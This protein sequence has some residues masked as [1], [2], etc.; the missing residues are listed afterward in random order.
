MHSPF[1][2]CLSST[3][4]PE[5]SR[6]DKVSDF[7]S[8]VGD[9]QTAWWIF[10]VV[11]SIL[12]F[13]SCLFRFRKHINQISLE[14][15]KAFQNTQKYIPEIYTELNQNMEF[16][17]Y[18]VHSKTWKRRVI[19]E[20]NRMF[21][22][23]LGKKIASVLNAPC[24][25]NKLAPWAS[26]GSIIT[27]LQER[28]QFLQKVKND[29][30]SNYREIGEFYFNLR[31]YIYYLPDELHV[32]QERCE[33]MQTQNMIVIGS[34]GNGKTNLLCRLVESI[35]FSKAPC[36]FINARDIH[37]DCISYVYGRILP[38]FSTR[39]A[40]VFLRIVCCALKIQRNYFYIIIDAIN[41]NDSDLFA[42]SIGKLTEELSQFSRIKFLCS[43]RSEY[44]EARYKRFFE[45]SKNQPHIFKLEQVDYTDRAKEKMLLAYRSFFNVAV[46]LSANVVDRLMHS[47]FLMR[48]FFEVNK[49]KSGQNLELRD[50]EIYKAYFDIVT[51]KTAPFDFRNA[52]EKASAIMISSKRF[53]G[54]NITELGLSTADLVQFRNALD[55]NLII[56]RSIHLG[57]GITERNSEYIY[58][59][60][61]ELRDYSLARHLLVS[62]E[63]KGDSQYLHFFEFANDLFSSKLSPLEGILKYAYYHFKHAG[64]YTL[65]QKL[66]DAYADFDPST[67]GQDYWRSRNQ[68]TFRNFG[69]SL[70]FQDSANLM[71]FELDYLST[72]ISSSPA[73]FW[74]IFWFLVRNE[75]VGEK[76]D[77]DLAVMILAEKIS[78]QALQSVVSVF[79][80]D[81]NDK[82]LVYRNEKRNISYLCDYV[83]ALEKRFKCLSLSMKQLLVILAALEPLEPELIDYEEFALQPEVT[84]ALAR[85][86]AAPELMS[87][88]DELK[89]KKVKEGES[90]QD[91][92]WFF[93]L[94]GDEL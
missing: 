77:S 63:A 5:E 85:R 46:P 8:C 2:A 14:Q 10:G 76:P 31:E 93:D 48:L 42:S 7:I 26:I 55:D 32:L 27:A 72:C 52:V 79:F 34:A 88:I 20:Y 1:L 69:V 25:T 90:F 4:V 13:I 75:M 44:F 23:K 58:F 91:Q 73:S 39:W 59:D 54:I 74:D 41:E 28:G 61:D 47:L 87:A 83:E 9:A 57:S 18:Y 94:F 15:I 16:L 64:V 81:R 50:A 17:R 84:A 22:D 12:V 29:E 11:V 43:C 80:A 65:C 70:V 66:L 6:V 68:R 67:F 49:N 92:T 37:A 21:S 82:Y 56:S 45:G 36:L 40:K 53:D 33:L 89:E 60:F 71:D 51:E 86:S 24:L 78:F 19:R 3:P 30:N 38:N 62:A 35:M